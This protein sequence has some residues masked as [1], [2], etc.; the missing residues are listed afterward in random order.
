MLPENEKKKELNE[1]ITFLRSIEFHKDIQAQI[2]VKNQKQKEFGFYFCSFY[3]S[4][5]D[6]FW[7]SNN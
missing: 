5:L 3:C 6:L 4:I 7:K 2:E 1:L